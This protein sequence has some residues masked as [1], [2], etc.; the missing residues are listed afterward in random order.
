M[1]RDIAS[2]RYQTLQRPSAVCLTWTT[3]KAD[4]EG[5]RHS[6]PVSTITL[7]LKLDFT[8]SPA[9]TSAGVWLFMASPGDAIDTL[10]LSASDRA[11]IL[12]EPRLPSAAMQRPGK[13]LP[14][15]D[16][17][18]WCAPRHHSRALCTP[19]GSRPCERALG[20]HPGKQGPKSQGPCT[21]IAS[22]NS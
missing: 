13:E 2:A 22:F 5:Q 4:G 18:S 21:N 1:T 8:I 17:Q 16:T 12:P 14:L 15:L 19:Q 6:Q 10:V 7:V 9:C 20:N 3:S 11:G